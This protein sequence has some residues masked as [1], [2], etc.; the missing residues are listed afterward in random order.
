MIR[1]VLGFAILLPLAVVIVALAVAN[2]GSV[3]IS[4]DPLSPANPAYVLHLPLYLLVFLLVIVGVLI[5]GVAA[6][7]KQGRWRRRARRL[8]TQL[9]RAYDEI[10]DL[11]GAA[12]VEPGASKTAARG[13]ALASAPV[14][15]ARPQQWPPPRALPPAA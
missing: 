6:W 10:K 12:A 14:D 9:R 2:R 15:T 8:E 5:G 1:K 11:R 3:A 7:V 4:L 13:T